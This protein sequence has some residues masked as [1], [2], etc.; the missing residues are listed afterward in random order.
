MTDLMTGSGVDVQAAQP[1]VVYINSEY[2]GVYNLREKVNEHF[3]DSRHQVNKGELSIVERN[4]ETVFGDNRH[5]NDM[6]SFVAQNDISGPDA[7]QTLASMMDI[8]NFLNYQVAQI[9]FDNHDWPGN[10]IK[11]WREQGGKWR[12]ILFDTDFGFNNFP[13]WHEINSFD[14]FGLVLDAN[15]PDW[16]NP[17]WSTLLL[18]KLI[19]NLEFR[20]ALINRFADALNSRFQSANVIT[21]IDKHAQ[22]YQT[23]MP[24]HFA[25]WSDEARNKNLQV[26][27]WE[28]QVSV[29]KNFANAR[30]AHLKSHIVNY[31]NLN[32][33]Y[34]L[35]IVN[36]DPVRG[37]VIINDNLVIEQAN[38]TGDYFA[39]NP[40]QLQAVPAN[41]YRFSHWQL[42]E[43]N[44]SSVI[45]LNLSENT[46]VIAVFVS[47]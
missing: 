36:Q 2:W 46:Q 4:G 1:T 30:P 35:E 21:A 10:N 37:S 32:D 14:S 34:Q 26:R 38:W 20:Q 43:Q 39:N 17:P 33:Y 24:A 13:E 8:E 23:E 5:F 16:P 11:M 41:G 45:E 28:Q 12:W 15:G 44:T 27:V 42:A 6:M 22:I 40:I 19:T 25:R 3:I 29:L 47:I 9:Y 31:F 18:R 7:Y